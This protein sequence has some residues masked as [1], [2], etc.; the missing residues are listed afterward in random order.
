MP[1]IRF[2]ASTLTAMPTRFLL[3]QSI[4]DEATRVAGEHHDPTDVL[5]LMVLAALPTRE[6]TAALRAAATELLDRIARG[7][8]TPRAEA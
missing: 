3:A 2:S 7:E 8:S 1:P 4:A 5:E 6:G